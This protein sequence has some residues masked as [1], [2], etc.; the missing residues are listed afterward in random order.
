MFEGTACSAFYPYRS[1]W[2]ELQC[3]GD[4]NQVCLLD[5]TQLVVLK[6]SQFLDGWMELFLYRIT[7]STVT[8]RRKET[9][10][11]SRR[12]DKLIKLTKSAN[13][14]WLRKGGRH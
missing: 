10:V 3:F 7:P 11:N 8:S 13:V 14:Q 12:R 4:I 5:G 9:S 6:T 1:F 2:W